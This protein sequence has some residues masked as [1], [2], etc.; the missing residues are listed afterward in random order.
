MSLSTRIGRRI[1][2]NALVKLATVILSITYTMLSVF[3]L[4]YQVGAGAIGQYSAAHRLVETGPTLSIIV[5]ELLLL[6]YCLVSLRLAPRK[7]ID[8]PASQIVAQ[9]N[10][11]IIE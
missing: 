9:S 2:G 10:E 8:D 5:A 7:R 4:K 6:I 1:G 11:V 3:L